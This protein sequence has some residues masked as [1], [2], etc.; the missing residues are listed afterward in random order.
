MYAKEQGEMAKN[1]ALYFLKQGKYNTEG[2]I[3]I[4]VSRGLAQTIT[5]N[6]TIAYNQCAY[7]G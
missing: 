5:S 1:L 2:D 4:L 7:L 3:V 6:M